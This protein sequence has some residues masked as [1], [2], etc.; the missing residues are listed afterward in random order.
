MY[1]CD[2]HC[3]LI[4]LLSCTPLDVN[5]CSSN[6]GG[7]QQLCADTQGSFTCGCSSGYVLSSDGR[8]CNGMFM[9]CK[10]SYVF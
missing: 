4:T 5:E 7:C 10:H 3:M 2:T 1:F 9:A 6:N 8:S